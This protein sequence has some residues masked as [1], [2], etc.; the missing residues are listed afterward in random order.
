MMDCLRETV[1]TW[2]TDNDSEREWKHGWN[3]KL[4]VICF[5]SKLTMTNDVVDP[6]RWIWIRSTLMVDDQRAQQHEVVEQ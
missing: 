3:S 2:Q 4:I 1:T 6:W 5:V